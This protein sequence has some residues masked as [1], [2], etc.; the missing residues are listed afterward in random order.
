MEW[1]TFKPVLLEIHQWHQSL[2]TSSQKWYNPFQI[3][4]PHNLWLGKVS[5]LEKNSSTLPNITLLFAKL[6]LYMNDLE[7]DLGEV[8][9]F[10]D[11]FKFRNICG[12]LIKIK[13]S[14]VF[15]V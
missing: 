12:N 2:T 10:F 6:L 3:L 14:P 5:Y 11:K 9:N 7:C 8:F 13:E 1:N 15:K 4:L